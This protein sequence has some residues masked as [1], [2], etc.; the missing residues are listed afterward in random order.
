MIVGVDVGTQS[1]KA[2]VLD[3]QLAVRGE[4]AV[5]YDVLHPRVDWAEQDPGDWE[6]ALPAAIGAALAAAGRSPADVRCLGIAGQLDGCVPVDRAGRALG[7]ALIWMDRRAAAVMPPLDVAALQRITG[8]IADPGHMAAKVRWLERHRPGAHRYHQPVSYLVA[9]LT[10]AN[11]YD[12][13]L[14]STTM[15]Y[16]LASREHAPELLA[17]FA[18]DPASLPA[19]AGAGELAGALGPAGAAL[20]GLP[21]GTPVAVGTGDDFATPLGAGLLTPGAA[22]CVLGTAEVVGALS[23]VPLIDEGRLVETHA[24][25]DQHFFIENPGWLSGG[26]VEWVCRLLGVAGAAALDRLAA[27][28]PPGCDGLVFTPALSGAMAPE[29]N[30]RARGCFHG[31]TAA[32]GPAHL[33]RSV[34]EGCAYA[35]R[36]VLDRLQALPL[37]L[38]RLLLCGGGGRS[39]LWAQIR[40][41]VSGLPVLA[42]ARSDTCAVGAGLLAAVVA[43]RCA[44]LVQAASGIPPATPAAE[45]APAERDCYDEGYRSYR[46]LFASLAPMR[47]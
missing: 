4:A 11:V 16:S 24:H 2:V 28:A 5:G 22:V 21:V 31:L 17:A 34:L 42:S 40:A 25:V 12:H 36:D 33:A 41:S 14:A 35:M 46:R 23:T 30:P 10:G 45:P 7:P 27:T 6:R 32:H 9:R 1:L 47:A 29:W 43:Q 26:A 20:C 8:L 39:R 13:G 19:I 37:S 38:D 3:E 18:I 15:L 44:D